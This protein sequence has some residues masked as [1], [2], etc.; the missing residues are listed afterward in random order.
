MYVPIVCGFLPEINVFV[1]V[2]IRIRL[3]TP[4]HVHA[5]TNARTNSLPVVQTA[6][7]VPPHSQTG[8]LAVQK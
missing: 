3:H 2:R 6:C 1:F 7:T 4:A 8:I 5:Y